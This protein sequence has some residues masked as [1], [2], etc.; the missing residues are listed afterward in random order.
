[1]YK[2]S[3]DTLKKS[4]KPVMIFS[5][6]ATL[7]IAT[8]SITTTMNANAFNFGLKSND[9][10]SGSIDT[11]S[12]FSCVGAAI[13]CV[14]TNQDNNNV[15]ANNSAGQ[16]N[17]PGPPPT[18]IECYTNN[19]TPEQIASIENIHGV[20]FEQF[21]DQ[22]SDLTED[23]FI[24]QVYGLGYFAANLGVD[25]DAVEA[26]VNCFFENYRISQ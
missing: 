24:R 8:M 22:L 6:I 11:N 13:N 7:L 1:M 12:L 5:V 25:A 10:N 21:C 16:S 23:E 15:V 14:N 19:L 20:N 4:T 9:V 2:V 18:C 17:P 26:M 3:R